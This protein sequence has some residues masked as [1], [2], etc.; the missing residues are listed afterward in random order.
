MGEYSVYGTVTDA[1]GSPIEGAELSLASMSGGN[2]GGAGRETRTASDGYYEFAGVEPGFLM[3]HADK[4]GYSTQTISKVMLDEP[5]D[6]VLEAA[7][8]VS[9][10]VLVRET[11][12]AAFYLTT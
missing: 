3:L 8:G 12:Q 6:I 5:T 11:G 4:E 1:T 10:R 2:L 9:G 7:S